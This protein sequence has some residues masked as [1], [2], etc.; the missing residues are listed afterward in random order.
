M[1]KHYISNTWRLP[2]L[3]TRERNALIA[4]REEAGLMLRSG[5]DV[6]ECPC[7]WAQDYSGPELTS[8]EMEV[9]MLEE[10]K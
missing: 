1:T 5:W 9:L 6:P 8:D 3:S 2:L 7:G 4:L 10:I